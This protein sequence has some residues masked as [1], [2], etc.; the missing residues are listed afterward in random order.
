MLKPSFHFPLMDQ[1]I[2][3]SGFWQSAGILGFCKC[4]P[5]EM[6]SAAS[7]GPSDINGAV[8]AVTA[9]TVPGP[10]VRI[11]Y[12]F[13]GPMV[14]HIT[15]MPGGSMTC[16]LSESVFFPGLFRSDDFFE[17]QSLDAPD[18]LAAGSV[19]LAMFCRF[20]MPSQIVQRPGRWS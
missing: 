2:D 5:L 8:P 6:R 9:P 7:C 10:G 11:P 13:V 16:A 18:Y 14:P 15:G 12:A 17:C 3:P 19:H 1:L 20:S 4:I